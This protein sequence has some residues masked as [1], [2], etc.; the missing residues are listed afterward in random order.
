MP[1]AALRYRELPPAPRLAPLVECLWL[2]EGDHD[3][4]AAAEPVLPDGHAELIVHLGARFEHY[5]AD[6][7]ITRQPA[8]LFAG[9]LTGPMA[10]RATG[11]IRILGIRFRPSG[12]AALFPMPQD[13]MA[14]RWDGLDAI[15]PVLAA[16]VQS[17]LLGADSLAEAVA[18]VDAVLA[19]RAVAAPDPSME[20]AADRILAT[21]GAVSLDGLARTT[22]LGVRQFRRRFLRQ[23]GVSPKRFARIAR[24]QRVFRALEQRPDRWAAVA[25]DCGYYDGA[26]LI[27]EFNEFAGH[28][29]GR[30]LAEA[31]EFTRVFLPPR[32]ASE[33]SNTA[34]FPRPSLGKSC[35]GFEKIASVPFHA[36]S[37]KSVGGRPPGWA[38]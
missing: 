20:Y 31:D 5:R 35:S 18:S 19:P 36:V 22:G 3:P 34:A 16:A 28:A 33:K 15:D 6:G 27:R 24:F 10:L 14:G 26:H 29:P 13:E 12:A 25:A 1:T 30:L 21:G 4:G 9:Q 37:L 7:G 8:A 2:L 32:R 23:V 38:T 17:R 11:P